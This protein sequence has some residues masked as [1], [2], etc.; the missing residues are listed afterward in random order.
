MK[1][2]SCN[3]IFFWQWYLLVASKIPLQDQLRVQR[4]YSD[5]VISSHCYFNSRETASDYT[6]VPLQASYVL[7]SHGAQNDICLYTCKLMEIHRCVNETVLFLSSC[8][9][10]RESFVVLYC[11]WQRWTGCQYVFLRSVNV[12]TWLFIPLPCNPVKSWYRGI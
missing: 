9:S 7:D 1:N 4:I 10:L 5:T 6:A 2:S 8:R 11:I 12:L 3:L